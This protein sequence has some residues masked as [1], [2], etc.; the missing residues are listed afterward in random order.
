VV[1]KDGVVSF[2]AEK[3]II[4]VCC[5]SYKQIEPRANINAKR[6]KRTMKFI[7][8]SCGNANFFLLFFSSPR[9]LAMS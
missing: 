8:F 4:P 9:S 6:K 7:V 1:L 3:G 5:S 2:F